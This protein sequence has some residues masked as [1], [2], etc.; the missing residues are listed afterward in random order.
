[1]WCVTGSSMRFCA[2]LAVFYCYFLLARVVPHSPIDSLKLLAKLETPLNVRFAPESAVV[3]PQ[4]LLCSNWKRGRLM[5]RPTG[6]L[7]SLLCSILLLSAGDIEINPGPVK[8]PCGR[9]RKAVKS[10][11]FSVRCTT[12]GFIPDASIWVILN[13]KGYL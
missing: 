13:I 2:V 12:S 6:R 5:L 7:P 4:E 3:S 10:V 9:C 11:V 8:Y 1:M